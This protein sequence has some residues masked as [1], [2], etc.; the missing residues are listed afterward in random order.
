MPLS[1]IEYSNYDQM[2]RWSAGPFVHS[3]LQFSHSYTCTQPS[4]PVSRTIAC[5]CGGGAREKSMRRTIEKTKLVA[6]RTHVLLSLLPC[7]LI[8]LLRHLRHGILQ[9]TRVSL[10]EARH[11][12]IYPICGINIRL[13]FLRRTPGAFLHLICRL[14][15]GNVVT[16]SVRNL[17]LGRGARAMGGG[18]VRIAQSSQPE[19]GSAPGSAPVP[20]HVPASTPVHSSSSR[21]ELIKR[22]CPS[23]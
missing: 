12:L 18:G 1:T 4:T 23:K 9:P 5:K 21:A 6:F 10:L 8:H 7:A 3:D 2:S 11:R 14:S 20:A 13:F 17:G 19:S 22:A 15:I 16:G